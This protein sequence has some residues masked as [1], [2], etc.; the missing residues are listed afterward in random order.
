MSIG[1]QVQQLARKLDLSPASISALEKREAD[2][3]ITLNSLR[4][5][6][7]GLDSELVYAL[8]PRRNLE[9]TV[10]DQA[11]ALATEIATGVAH[12]MRLEEQG[13]SKKTTNDQIEE[14]ARQILSD[15]PARI[16][17]RHS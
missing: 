6:A 16:W 13:V 8:V 10:T 17:E 14:L 7:N 2:G 4:N 3:T 12:S 11:R 5:L 1:M 15:A 9:K